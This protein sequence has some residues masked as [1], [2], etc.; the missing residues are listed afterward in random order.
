MELDIESIFF[1][2]T[3]QLGD[4]DIDEIKAFDYWNSDQTQ[5]TREM[6][7]Q[8]RFIIAFI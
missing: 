8:S 2:L 3:I 5:Q 1:L 6:N 7:R 4:L